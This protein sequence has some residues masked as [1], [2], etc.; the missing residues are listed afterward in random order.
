MYLLL[1]FFCGDNMDMSEFNKQWYQD[2]KD[3]KHILL[4]D[5]SDYY[6]TSFIYDQAIGYIALFD[7]GSLVGFIHPTNVLKV[8]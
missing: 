7:N 8:F 5:N 4:T 3:K 1:Y 2:P 6:A